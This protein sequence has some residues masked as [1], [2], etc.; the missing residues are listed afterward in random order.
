MVTGELQILWWLGSY[1]FHGDWGVINFMATG[2]LTP[3][4]GDKG[5]NS[6]SWWEDHGEEGVNSILWWQGS[7]LI[8]MVTLRVT[9]FMVTVELQISWW[10]ESYKWK[11]VG[12]VCSVFSYHTEIKLVFMIVTHRNQR[13]L[14][15]LSVTLTIEASHLAVDNSDQYGLY[16]RW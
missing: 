5:V 3:F 14:E 4:H 9:N 6:I 16:R 2:E 12:C 8:S 1:K 15:M 10:Q 13:T 11:Y 7:W